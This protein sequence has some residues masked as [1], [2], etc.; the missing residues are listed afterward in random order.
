MR[1]SLRDFASRGYFLF[2]AGLVGCALAGIA[3]LNLLA[4]TPNANPAPI[5][6][7]PST[8]PA[9]SLAIL[10]VEITLS[11]SGAPASRC[12]SNVAPRR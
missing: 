4:A 5:A 9:D 8:T 12:L 10:P 7:T 6:A 1:L 2:A 3:G 11:G